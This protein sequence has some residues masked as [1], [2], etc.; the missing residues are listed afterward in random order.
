MNTGMICKRHWAGMAIGILASMIVLVG[1][2]KTQQVL[3]REQAASPE[4]LEGR[5]DLRS[6]GPI[7]S[8]KTVPT[9]NSIYL[10][11]TAD[12]KISGFGGCNRYFGG[13]GYLEGETDVVRIWRTGSTRMACPEPIMT[14]EHRFLEELS[15][16][17]RYQIE[18][19]NL[20]LYYDEGRSVLRFSRGT[21]P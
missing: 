1:C 15:R 5:W 21:Q 3:V 14:Q 4:T 6:Y 12:G 18:G 20:R 8:Q 19:T 9:D 16:A 7:G 10:V 17:S 13:W 11:F 2:S